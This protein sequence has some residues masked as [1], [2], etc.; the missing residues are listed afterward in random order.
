MHSEAAKYRTSNSTDINRRKMNL[1]AF[2]KPPAM[3][4]KPLPM[5]D[6]TPP[7]PSVLVLGGWEDL[8]QSSLNPCVS[9]STTLLVSTPTWAA[10]AINK[11]LTASLECCTIAAVAVTEGFKTALI[12]SRTSGNMPVS[13]IITKD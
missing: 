8:S 4:L 11:A 10:S 2:I 13:R 3:N 7:P 6:Q 9:D 12:K 1:K 5:A